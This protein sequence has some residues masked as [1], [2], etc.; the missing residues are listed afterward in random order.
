MM[1]M[2]SRKIKGATGVARTTIQDYIKRCDTSGLTMHELS[3]FND[4]ALGLKLFAD[5]RTTVLSSKKVMPDY[6]HV[7]N[8]LKQAKKTKVTLMLLWDE[9]KQEH[10]IVMSTLSSESITDVINR[11]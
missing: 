8:K 4:D 1:K 2:S 11:N 3:N 6:E 5:Q 9:Y 7:H 10:P